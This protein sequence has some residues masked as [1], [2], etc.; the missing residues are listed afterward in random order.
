MWP[1][2]LELD[3]VNEDAAGGVVPEGIE[4]DRLHHRSAV[5]GQHVLPVG[6]EPFELG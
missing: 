2:Q 4:Q 5:A 1:A 6:S 3:R